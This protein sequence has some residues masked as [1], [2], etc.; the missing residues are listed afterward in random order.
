MIFSPDILNNKYPVGQY[1]LLI[2]SK[3]TQNKCGIMEEGA[4][5][6]VGFFVNI[7]I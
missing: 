1:S 4:R 2:Q 6:R 7:K 3:T 5:G